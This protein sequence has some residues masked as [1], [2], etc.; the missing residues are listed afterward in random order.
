MFRFYER[1]L[2][3]L[4]SVLLLTFVLELVV[5]P[6]ELHAESKY[7]IQ[8]IDD[9]LYRFT[10]GKY[11][12]VFLVTRD[13]ILV[14]DPINEDAARWLKSEL[15]ER[16]DQPIRY[17]IYSHS[18]PDHTYGG[19]VFND[20]EVTFVAHRLTRQN[21]RRTRAK[22]KLPDLV[23]DEKTDL[24]LGDHTI[25]LRYHGPNNGRGSISMRFRPQN[26]LFVVDWIVLGRMPYKD[27][28]GYDIEGMIDSTREVLE[29]KFDTFVGGHGDLGTKKDVRS[30]LRYLE[31][32]YN[33]VL[34]GILDKKS[35]KTIQRDVDLSEFSDLRKFEDW[36]DLNIKAVWSQLRNDSYLH[37]RDR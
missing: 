9:S 25:E 26:T 8:S 33:Q 12:S 35:L 22:T 20:A 14:T 1:S 28:P 17:V 36:R 24:H 5:S 15:R 11:H 7:K 21:L 3:L 4:I 29:I 6:S 23:F 18:H 10:A 16:F 2:F 27:L 19:H 31:S 32:L 30:Y 37:L 34:Q 13:G